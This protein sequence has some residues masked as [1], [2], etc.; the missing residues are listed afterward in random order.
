MQNDKSAKT[1]IYGMVINESSRDVLLQLMSDVLIKN[2]LV[3]EDYGERVIERE[4]SFPTG[5]PSEPIA[6]AIPHSEREYVNNSG[7]VVARLQK[8]VTFKRMDLPEEG[9][10]VRLVFLLAIEKDG[11]QVK[12]IMEIMKMVQDQEL[13]FNLANA[14]TE[15]DVQYFVQSKLSKGEIVVRTE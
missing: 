5:V 3:K 7:I 9:L 6:V 12:T 4:N 15:K 2:G 10:D 8:P 11:D 14:E 13:L 1:K